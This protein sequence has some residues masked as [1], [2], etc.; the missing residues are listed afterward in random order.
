MGDGNFEG[1]G[2]FSPV[3]RAL[4]GKC[5][6]S[7]KQFQP[8]KVNLPGKQVSHRFDFQG[9]WSLWHPGYF[10]SCLPDD[11]AQLGGMKPEFSSAQANR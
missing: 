9:D 10:V 4:L 7:F 5:F 3:D 6:F 2:F 11:R 1:E 8:S